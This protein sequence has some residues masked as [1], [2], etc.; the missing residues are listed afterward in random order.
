M[1][2]MVF[3]SASERRRYY[4][5][6]FELSKA[7]A[8]TNYW[9]GSGGYGG[10][11][12]AVAKG[13]FPYNRSVGF[14]SSDIE[15]VLGCKPNDF[16]TS[17]IFSENIDVRTRKMLEWGDLYVVFPGGIGT[18]REVMSAVE[19]SILEGRT[20]EVILIGAEWEHT[21]NAIEFELRSWFPARTF[22]DRIKFCLTV[23][24]AI[25]NIERAYHAS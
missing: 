5:Q 9:I 17:K 25:T 12:E 14:L 21:I 6:A 4:G 22:Y 24:A 8:M 13:A 15:T 20:Q 18:L 2:I 7:L 19:F 10:I 23:D 11:M 1:K 16:L 3:G